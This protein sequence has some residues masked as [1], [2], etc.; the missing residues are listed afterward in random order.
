MLKRKGGRKAWVQVVTLFAVVLGSE[1][2]ETYPDGGE[3]RGAGTYRGR[4]RKGNLKK[5]SWKL[6][7]KDKN[8]STF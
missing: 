6:R 4:D 8:V 2:K 3:K 7:E 1:E 5:K